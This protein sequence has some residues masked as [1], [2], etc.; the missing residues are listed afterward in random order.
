MI[1]RQCLTFIPVRSLLGS[2]AIIT[3]LILYTKIAAPM[4]K[5]S[6][7]NPG[8][9]SKCSLAAVYLGYQGQTFSPDH[10]L[11]LK[12]RAVIAGGRSA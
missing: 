7:M 4:E 5:Q 11:T 8:A 12:C 10:F 6:V 1:L 3:C 2:N 9:F